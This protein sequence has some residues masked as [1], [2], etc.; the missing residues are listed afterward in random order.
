MIIAGEAS[1]DLHA[2]NVIKSLRKIDASADIRFFGGD[3]MAKEA[4]RDPD[5]HYDQCDGLQRGAAQ[6]A[7]NPP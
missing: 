1:G 3:L 7:C 4:G 6:V 2:A 5:L